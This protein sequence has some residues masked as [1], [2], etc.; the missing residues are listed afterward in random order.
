MHLGSLVQS[1]NFHL[2]SCN[3]LAMYIDLEPLLLYIMNS[4]GPLLPT[5]HHSFEATLI[6]LRV[7]LNIDHF[8]AAWMTPL[9]YW[10][11][12]LKL[13]LLFSL[14]KAPHWLE[15][16][17]Q[18]VFWLPVYSGCLSLAAWLKSDGHGC[19]RQDSYSSGLGGFSDSDYSNNGVE[20]RERERGHSVTVL[21]VRGQTARAPWFQSLN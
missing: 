15:S 16:V 20:N 14:L 6:A 3:P 13:W 8:E 7:Y 11:C 4:K 10:S 19:W 9:G 5:T 18:A 17:T 1:E 2:E 21:F 12:W